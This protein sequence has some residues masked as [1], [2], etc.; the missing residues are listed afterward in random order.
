MDDIMWTLYNAVM[1]LPL[2][3]CHRWFITAG[4]EFADPEMLL[5][6]Y[7]G[8]EGVPSIVT[9]YMKDGSLYANNKRAL[10]LVYCGGLRFLGMDLEDPQRVRMRLEFFTRNGHAWGVRCGS[11]IF[12][13]EE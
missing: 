11:R 1:G 5:G 2:D 8:H 13:L 12:S 9:V 10:R 4:R 7:V 6:R 3:T